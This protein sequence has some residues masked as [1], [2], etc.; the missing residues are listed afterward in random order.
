MLKILLDQNFNHRILRGLLLRVP[1]L[2][3]LTTHEAGLSE[4]EDPELLV[5]AA[6]AERLLISH[7]LSTMPT[8]A[9]SVMEAGQIIAGV[10]L[11]SDQ[12]PIG[13]VVD[14]LELI[15]TCTETSEWQNVVQFLRL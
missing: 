2:D 5:W 1:K 6:Q 8:H 14:R 7:D 10:I 4:I 13:P 15:V 11:V 3:Y 12:L 9:K